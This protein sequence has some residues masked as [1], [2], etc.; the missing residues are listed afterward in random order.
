MNDH[1]I[2]DDHCSKMMMMKKKRM[3]MTTILRTTMK[4]LVN[5]RG[6]PQNL[7]VRVNKDVGLVPNLV[8]PVGAGI[9]T[10]S[11]LII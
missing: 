11:Y 4:H 2:Q 6:D 8:I 5:G 1:S 3:V 10:I 7:A 9:Q